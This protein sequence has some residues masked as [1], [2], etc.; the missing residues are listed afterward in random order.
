MAGA[1]P[2]RH[3]FEADESS[4][5]GAAVRQRDSDI[6]AMVRAALDRRDVLLAFQPIV[7]ATD[8]Q[9]TA[10]YEG[11]I[12]VLDD[13]GRVIPAREF[14]SACETNEIGRI[15]DCLALEMGL[16]ALHEAP[17]LRLAINMSARS[18]GYPRWMQTLERGLAMAPTLAE[19][20]I[21]E[22]TESS[23]IVM[24]DITSVFM[25][26]LQT[27]GVSFALDDFGAGYTAFRYFR[28]FF[29]D[30]LKIDGQFVK[31]IARD[32]DNRVIVE[33]MISIARHFDMFTV[34]EFVENAEDAAVLSEIGV[35]CLQGYH[36]GAPTTS[37]S[38]REF[39]RGMRRAG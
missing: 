39:P 25:L 30:I 26:D 6:L 15:I 7:R 19:R 16:T 2:R 13:T 1:E 22:I 17:G 37:P 21:I 34:A 23:A 18:I 4:P 20:L 14:I 32:P 33:A 29:F 8:H 36:F 31:G 28:D 27:R 24:P 9:K 38:W 12:R 5:L 10:F 3:R 35:D 11:L